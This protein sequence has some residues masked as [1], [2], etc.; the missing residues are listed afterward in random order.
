MHIL[1]S[2]Y[3]NTCNDAFED[4]S[5]KWFFQN[6]LSIPIKCRL[7]RYEK[8]TDIFIK[9][10]ITACEKKNFSELFPSHKP[11]TLRKKDMKRKNREAGNM[12][13]EQQK[14]EDKGKEIIAGNSELTQRFRIYYQMILTI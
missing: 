14:E 2:A 4:I 7:S 10:I 11:K 3:I 5:C 8:K 13:R 6:F 12:K 1:Y 9:R